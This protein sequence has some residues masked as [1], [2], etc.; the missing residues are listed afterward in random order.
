MCE[1]ITQRVIPSEVAGSQDS[2]LRLFRGIPRLR[3]AALGMTA[4]FGDIVAKSMAL[5]KSMDFFGKFSANA[6]RRN[7][8]IHACFAETIHRAKSPQ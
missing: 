5:E 2:A 4:T 3:F 7:N 1:W 8:L 6:F